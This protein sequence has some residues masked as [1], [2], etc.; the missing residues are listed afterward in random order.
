MVDICPSVTLSNPSI[1]GKDV[2]EIDPTRWSPERLKGDQLNP[3]AF[4][5]FSNGPRICIGRLFAMVEIKLIMAEM[6]RNY[7]FVNVEKPFTV[8]NPGFTLRPAGMEV[9]LERVSPS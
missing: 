6:V 8:E 9:R 1:W 4:S 2:D 3:Y 5:P 7:R